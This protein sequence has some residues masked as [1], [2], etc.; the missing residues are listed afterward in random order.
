MSELPHSKSRGFHRFWSEI[1]HCL[2]HFFSLKS[3]F[4]KNGVKTNELNERW[5]WTKVRI[6]RR[7]NSYEK[8][9]TDIFRLRALL[10][11]RFGR[12]KCS[13]ANA[14]LF[15]IQKIS[16][17]AI[18][19]HL[20]FIFASKSNDFNFLKNFYI[21]WQNIIRCTNWDIIWKLCWRSLVHAL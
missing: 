8:K 9:D 13:T 15:P 16:R 10:N 17:D 7:L 5:K 12:K 11:V 1:F 2:F 18:R 3:T 21:V 20:D 19:A 6:K 4:R 14:F